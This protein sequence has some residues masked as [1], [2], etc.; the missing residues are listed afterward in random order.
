M[1]SHCKLFILLLLIYSCAV[2]PALGS[3]A[4]PVQARRAMVVTVHQ[5][6]SR[7]GA[8]M[9]KTGGNAVDAAVAVGFVLAVVHPQAGNLGGGGF[10][11]T[12]MADGKTHFIDYRERLRR[13]RRQICIWMPRAMLLRMRAPLD[14]KRSGSQDPWRVWCM[15]RKS[16]AS[17]RCSK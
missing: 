6:A 10:M 8:Q 1:C 9:M 16:M 11:L 15:R 13:R 3:A 5:L 2:I 17:Y 12:R 4:I 7:A 14:T